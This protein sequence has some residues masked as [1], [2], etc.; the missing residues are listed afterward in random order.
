MTLQQDNLTLHDLRR[1][2]QESGVEFV[3][4]QIVE[5][6]VSVESSRIAAEIIFLLKLHVSKS[7]DA[8]ICDSSLGYR[9]F[10]DDPARHR[11]PDVSA[12]RN[13]RMQTLND[14]DPRLMPIPPDLAVEV[15]SPTDYA[16]DVDEKLE[17]YLSNGFKLIWVVNP[18]TRTVT[19][20]RGD[21]SI[22]RLHEND[23]ITGESA[24]PGFACKVAQF[25]AQTTPA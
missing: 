6:P 12:I 15:L 16:Y 20:H 24:L 9:C 8:M 10:S 17:D 19:I 7:R 3:N 13:E 1:L 22:G 4:G 18:L 21:G 5:K 2:E 14:P 23:E 25:F 11:K